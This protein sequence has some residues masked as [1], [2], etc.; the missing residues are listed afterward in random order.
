MMCAPVVTETSLHVTNDPLG[1]PIVTETS[2]SVTNDPLGGPIVT[3]SLS[4]CD[5]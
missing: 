5:K 1:G 4:L 3:E 2:L